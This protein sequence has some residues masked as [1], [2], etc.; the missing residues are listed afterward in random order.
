MNGSVELRKVYVKLK[1]DHRYDAVVLPNQLLE[2]LLRY[3][4]TIICH[5]PDRRGVPLLSL[6]VR[7]FH[8]YVPPLLSAMRSICS[9]SLSIIS[10][11]VLF[12]FGLLDNALLAVSRSCLS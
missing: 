6:Q 2:D 4:L 5:F 10:F 11:Y 8:M 9:K 1:A 7:Q 12:K 3:G